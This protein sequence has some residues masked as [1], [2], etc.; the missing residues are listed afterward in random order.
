MA[1]WKLVEEVLLG[2]RQVLWLQHDGALAHC[3][4]RC[5]AI[6]KRVR[7]RKVYWTSSVDGMASSVAGSNSSGF[8]FVRK[9]EECVYAVPP[10]GIEDPAARLLCQL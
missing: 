1:F 9:P 5:L 10:S 2:V 3:G 4:G 6:V 7:F 8:I